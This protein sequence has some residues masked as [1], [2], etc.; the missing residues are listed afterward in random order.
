[1]GKSRTHRHGVAPAGAFTLVELPF[2]RLRIVRKCKSKAFTLVE[3]LV[4]ILIISLLLAILVPTIVKVK[5]LTMVN[6]SR[7]TINLLQGGCDM[8]RTEL[9]EYPPSDAWA[10][11]SGS[12]LYGRHRLVLALV[13]YQ[14]C[15]GAEVN[16]GKVGKGF[17]LESRGKTYGPY[18]AEDARMIGSPAAF[19]DAFENQVYYYRYNSGYASDDPGGPGMPDYAKDLSGNFLRTD[20]VLMTKGPDDAWTSF[21]SDTTT[22]DITNFIPE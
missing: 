12:T 10:L 6:A 13:G 19:M 22:D 2:D 11:P 7:A 20:F 9:N 8:Y 14:Y 3:L 5:V 15:D 4:V 18:A 21:R 17:R 1:M 16:D